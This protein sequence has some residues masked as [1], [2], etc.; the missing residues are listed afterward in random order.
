MVWM[1]VVFYYQWDT[2]FQ[3]S[4]ATTTWAI[5]V[6]VMMYLYIVLAGVYSY[7]IYYY[8]NAESNADLTTLMVAWAVAAVIH[9]LMAVW[10][11]F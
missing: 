3:S 11:Y 4:I 6:Q 1:G 8:L 10:F 2:D 5:V 9:V 7:L